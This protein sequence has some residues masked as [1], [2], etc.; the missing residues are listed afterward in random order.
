MQDD[1]DEANEQRGEDVGGGNSLQ[2]PLAS[3]GGGGEEGGA[4][5][6]GEDRP[7]AARACV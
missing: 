7:V 1:E 4:T 3:G 6:A 5:G 2:G